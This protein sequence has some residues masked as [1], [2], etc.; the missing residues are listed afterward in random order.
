MGGWKAAWTGDIATQRWHRYP[1]RRM[2]GRVYALFIIF[3]SLHDTRSQSINHPPTHTHSP[4][5]QISPM[6]LPL[7]Y[8]NSQYGSNSN[9]LIL[10]N[11]ILLLYIR[12]TSP[13]NRQKHPPPTEPHHPK[14]VIQKTII[15]HR[16]INHPCLHYLLM[17][18]KAH[19]KNK[20]TV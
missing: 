12:T 2:E 19:Y 8:F 10:T 17:K 13:S 18:T 9:F 4:T 20:M 16:M 3:L 7:I 5:L 15:T 6:E 14:T 11:L 1:R